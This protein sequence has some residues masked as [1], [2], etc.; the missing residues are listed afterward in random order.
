LKKFLYFFLSLE[1][2]THAVFGKINHEAKTQS[3]LSRDVRIPSATRSLLKT[4]VESLTNLFD[5]FA[6][7]AACVWTDLSDDDVDQFKRLKGARDAIA[8]GRESEPP[9]GFA[10]SAERLAHRILWHG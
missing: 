7:C 1:I 2:E 5:R 4:Q 9:N 3:I 10:R 8:H 6:W